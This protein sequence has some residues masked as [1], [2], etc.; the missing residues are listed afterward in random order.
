VSDY[1]FF[2]LTPNDVNVQELSNGTI[3]ASKL[4]LT[5]DEMRHGAETWRAHVEADVRCKLAEAMKPDVEYTIGPGEWASTI[6][7]GVMGN[8]FAILAVPVTHLRQDTT[9][10]A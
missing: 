6:P 8:G 1:W 4:S 2:S 5:V 3:Y 10:S 9:S 7:A